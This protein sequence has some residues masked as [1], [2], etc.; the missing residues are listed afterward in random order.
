MQGTY[1]VVAQKASGRTIRHPFSVEE[2]GNYCC[3]FK[4]LTVPWVLKASLNRV[5][6]LARM[7][8]MAGKMSLCPLPPKHRPFLKREGW[9]M[10]VTCLHSFLSPKPCSV[11]L[12]T[13]HLSKG[14]IRRSNVLGSVCAGNHKPHLLS[15]ATA[16]SPVGY[17]PVKRHAISLGL[18]YL[19]P[20]VL[21]FWCRLGLSV[22]SDLI[23]PPPQAK[24]V[25]CMM[26]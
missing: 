4:L 10:W 17:T 7:S 22:N 12:L 6:D 1:T 8:S 26:L 5:V 2:Y 21:T 11:A 19:R 9:R 3:T 15:E 24:S 25:A 14:P 20:K 16:S 13:A 23:F 18:P